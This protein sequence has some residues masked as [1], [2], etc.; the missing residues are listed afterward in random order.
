M[1]DVHDSWDAQVRTVLSIRREAD[2]LQ[3][4]A[5]LRA[6]QARL[7]DVVVEDGELRL[8]LE[9]PD[10]ART[11]LHP[12]V[13][14]ASAGSTPL[15]EARLAI[16]NVRS[17]SIETAAHASAGQIDVAYDGVARTWT[18]RDSHGSLITATV[19]A[20][21]ASVETTD[22]EIGRQSLSSMM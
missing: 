12:T 5:I 1:L 13:P 6:S 18:L 3:A 9:W 15:I 7:A 8:P 19:D 22:V 16:R 17:S 21:D 2:L 14:G 20:L 11:E 4:A 10:W